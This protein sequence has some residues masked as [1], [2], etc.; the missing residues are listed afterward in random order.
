[1]PGLSARFA[2]RVRISITSLRTQPLLQA[3][4][5]CPGNSPN[6]DV[7]KVVRRR[8]PFSFIYLVVLSCGVGIRSSGERD[9]GSAPA[10]PRTATE[11][12]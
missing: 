9:R 4:A 7:L 2:V 10:I 8:L 11:S 6:A 1:M 12:Q 5:I 3:K